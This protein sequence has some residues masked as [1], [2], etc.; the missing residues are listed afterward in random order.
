M[1]NKAFI[2]PEAPILPFISPPT[3]DLFTQF[4]KVFLK[5]TQARDQKQL[6]P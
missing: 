2:S 3:N 5:N 4:M 1:S 6:E